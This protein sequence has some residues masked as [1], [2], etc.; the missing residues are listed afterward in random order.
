MKDLT[1]VLA[2]DATRLAFDCSVMGLSVALLHKGRVFSVQEHSANKQTAQLMVMIEGVLTQAG[3]GYDEVSTLITTY[4]PGSFTGIRI[5]LAAAQGIVA[6]R[7]MDVMILTSLQAVAMSVVAQCDDAAFWVALNAGKGE[8]YA[9]MFHV[10]QSV[11]A[12][13][14]A[15]AL[16]SPEAFVP[17]L[18]SDIRV[19]GNTASLLVDIDSAR[20]IAEATLPAAQDFVHHNAPF[21]DIHQLVPLYIRA[22]DAKLPSKAVVLE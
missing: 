7:N 18:D 10:K 4:G 12:P 13:Q 15:I 20:W 5:G 14:N 21:V 8:I 19:A 6:A 1:P 3:I 9:Q 17:V 11:A 22:P 16:Y 2:H